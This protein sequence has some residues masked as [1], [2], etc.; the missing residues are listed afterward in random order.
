[1]YPYSFR[2]DAKSLQITDY[3]IPRQLGYNFCYMKLTAVLFHCCSILGCSNSS[4]ETI[5]STSR[6]LRCKQLRRSRR[7]VRSYALRERLAATC[8]DTRHAHLKRVKNLKVMILNN[9]KK[10]SLKSWKTSW[11]TSVD[12]I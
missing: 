10:L 7:V 12:L 2:V 4:V 8:C 1:M 9:T 6:N 11:N 3:Y 5:A